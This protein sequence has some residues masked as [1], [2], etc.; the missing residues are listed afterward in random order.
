[1]KQ[2]APKKNNLGVFIS[3]FRFQLLCFD[4]LLCKN[5]VFS[6]YLN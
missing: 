4:D 6:K 3:C 2:K 1:M 5:N